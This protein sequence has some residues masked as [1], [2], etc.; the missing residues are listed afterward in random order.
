MAL[1][2]QEAARAEGMT[3]VDVPNADELRRQLETLGY[4]DPSPGN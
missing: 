2:V 1:D 4:V 3:G